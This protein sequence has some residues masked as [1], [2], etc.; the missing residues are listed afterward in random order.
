MRKGVT[1]VHLNSSDFAKYTDLQ[2]AIAKVVSQRPIDIAKKTKVMNHLISS[3]SQNSILNKIDKVFIDRSLNAFQAYAQVSMNNSQMANLMNYLVLENPELSHLCTLRAIIASSVLAAWKWNSP[4][5]QSRIIL[6]ALLSDVGLRDHPGLLRKKRFEYTGEETKL[7]EQ[8]PF[9]SFQILNQIPGMPEEILHVALQH[10]EN[11]AGLGFPQ[12]LTRNKTHAFSK[13]IHGVSELV[14]TL[15][16]QEDPS[17]VQK[18]LDQIHAIQTKIVSEQVLKTL[19]IIFKAKLPKQ[20]EG[21]LL[22]TE[23]TRVA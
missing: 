18:A 17:D 2:F 7:Y 11:A 3:V 10:H 14:E 15:Q 13:V 1:H 23:T 21:L 8:H 16:Q 12:K 20:L 6:S 22:P 19:Y 4:K 5:V 9:K